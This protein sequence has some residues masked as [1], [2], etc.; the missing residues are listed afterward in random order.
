MAWSHKVAAR[1]R[2]NPLSIKKQEHLHKLDMLLSTPRPVRI[3]LRC[4]PI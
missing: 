2:V 4:D 3:V 1:H